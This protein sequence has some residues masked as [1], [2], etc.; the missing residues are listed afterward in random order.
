MKRLLV[1]FIFCFPLV[2]SPAISFA[3]D[4]T[5][6]AA[7]EIPVYKKYG[8]IRYYESLW[9]VSKKLRPNKLVS[10]QQT[11]VAIYKLNPD[12]FFEGDI[13]NFIENSVINVP[14]DTFIKK[15]TNQDAINLINKYSENNKTENNKT[16][17]RTAVVANNAEQL[18]TKLPALSE[19]EDV[20]AKELDSLS[21]A[22]VDTPE[23]SLT[24]ALV[25]QKYLPDPEFQ[26][27]NLS[28]NPEPA[29]ES[30]NLQQNNSVTDDVINTPSPEEGSQSLIKIQ[31]LQTELNSVNDQLVATTK[32]NQE[33]QSKL[34]LLI[35]DIDLLKHKMDTESAVEVTLLE[36]LAQ[37]KPEPS[38]AA[39]PVI[40]NAPVN[41]QNGSWISAS[42]TNL[43]LVAGSLLLFI[44]LIFSLIFRRRTKFLVDEKPKLIS[45]PGG[46]FITSSGDLQKGYKFNLVSQQA[47]EIK[48]EY[49]HGSMADENSSNSDIPRDNPDNDLRTQE[50][51]IDKLKVNEAASNVNPSI[52]LFIESESS[53]GQGLN[54]KLAELDVDQVDKL[55]ELAVN[56]ELAPLNTFNL[57]VSA[58]E[59]AQALTRDLSENSTVI[60]TVNVDQPIYTA[61]LNSRD[62]SQDEVGQSK[63]IE[64][65]IAVAV[66]KEQ[67]APAI[68]L[69]K[70]DNY[71][72]IET[73]L[74]NGAGDHPDDLY[75]EFDFDL[76]LDEFPDMLGENTTIDID[77]DQY[78][79]NARLD[80]ARA[81]L[82][83]DDKIRAK[84]ILLASI[85]NSNV[86]QRQEIDKLLSRL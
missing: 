12:A 54:D 25:D 65:S 40:N 44:A 31:A 59:Q 77:D 1:I 37:Y 70:S 72:A 34:Q 66:E 9:S 84:K 27:E 46:Y 11:L 73:L 56:D 13:N 35:D 47:S 32:T 17:N 52:A 39:Q 43:W 62:Q 79:T 20:A 23:Q 41:E 58:P 28:V 49:L 61:P 64:K 50:E 33:F 7:Q 14:T 81:Y 67:S 4:S 63:K 6:I 86:E 2:L 30:G 24:A 74:K 53:S 45:G 18:I 5:T 80:L 42:S 15:Q 68:K 3:L 36:L 22:A 69:K 71:I 60:E 55:A 29:T 26:A 8:P 85:E 19:Q 48:P 16:E 76:G 75:S 10:I 83:I 78:G 38:L 51:H 21:V 57:N 82:E